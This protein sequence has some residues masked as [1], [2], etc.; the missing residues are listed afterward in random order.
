MLNFFQCKKYLKLKH[1]DREKIHLVIWIDFKNFNYPRNDKYCL[2]SVSIYLLKRQIRNVTRLTIIF[3]IESSYR[4][5]I[6]IL[7]KFKFNSFKKK[8]LLFPL[9]FKKTRYIKSK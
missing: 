8:L 5:F 7:N 1:K 4:F 2:K 9:M 3:S 6:F